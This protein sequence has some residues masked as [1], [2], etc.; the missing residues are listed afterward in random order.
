VVQIDR[1]PLGGASR[2]IPRR[3]YRHFVRPHVAVAIGDPMGEFPRANSNVGLAIR[4]A[5]ALSDLVARPRGVNNR[6]RGIAPHMSEPTS[7][8]GH[9]KGERFMLKSI[10]AT[11]AAIALV[12]AAW[13]L[14]PGRSGEA[15]TESGSLYVNAVDLD[16]VPGQIDNYLAAA[17]ENGAAAVTEPGCREFNITVSQKD[18]NHV[19][20]F[21]VYDNAAALESHR[22]TDHFKKYSATVA[23]MVAKREVRPFSSIEMNRK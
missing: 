22:A 11:V 13:I 2:E 21:E 23:N 12:S 19:F 16:I 3:S 7:K 5:I 17:K 6:A 18:P 9:A 10:T 8:E 4:R 20:L 15:A 14:L 1:N